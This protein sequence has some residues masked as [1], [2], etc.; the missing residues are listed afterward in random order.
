MIKQ[1]KEN[2][3]K[4]DQEY[5]DDN[6]CVT[7]ETAEDNTLKN[8]SLEAYVKKM[9]GFC[10][11]IERIVSS[12]N[13]FSKIESDERACELYRLSRLNKAIRSELKKYNGKYKEQ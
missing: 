4:N 5:E 13:I 3:I 1:E 2:I 8:L 7:G 6:M 12:P 10:A 11:E 9:D